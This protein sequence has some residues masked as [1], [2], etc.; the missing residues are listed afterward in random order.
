MP[1][2]PERPRFQNLAGRTPEKKEKTMNDIL[3]EYREELPA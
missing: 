3:K 1:D 2:R